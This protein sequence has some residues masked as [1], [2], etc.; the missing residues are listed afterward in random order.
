MLVVIHR[1]LLNQNAAVAAQSEQ[2]GMPMR[3]P[4]LRV[5]RSVGMAQKPGEAVRPLGRARQWSWRVA[6]MLP[7]D[8]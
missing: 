4:P 6:A 5:Q 7:V 2:A 8:A 3:P 1:L